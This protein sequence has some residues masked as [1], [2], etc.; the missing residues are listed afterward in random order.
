M[1]VRV[2][3]T[4]STT[5]VPSR[6]AT[7]ASASLQHCRYSGP[8]TM[9]SALT[10]TK[11]GGGHA[12]VLGAQ[13]AM[14]ARVVHCTPHAGCGVLAEVPVHAFAALG[15]T[16]SR[17]E[18]GD[19]GCAA[20]TFQAGVLW[21]LKRHQAGC[22]VD[23]AV[24]Q[25]AYVCAASYPDPQ[26]SGPHHLN[27]RWHG[28]GWAGGGDLRSSRGSPPCTRA[29]DSSINQPVNQTTRQSVNAHRAPSVRGGVQREGSPA[30]HMQQW[31]GR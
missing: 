3:T 17:D 14:A 2:L 22:K 27:H 20:R 1:T 23:G 25:S 10:K 4:P 31:R 12:G 5:P 9:G 24:H 29:H 28:G 30:P 19:A 21:P 18:A 11:R 13:A 7:T 15:R 16:L 26:P 6:W 8:A